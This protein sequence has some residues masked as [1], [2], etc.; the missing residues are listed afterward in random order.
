MLSENGTVVTMAGDIGDELFGGYH[1][2]FFMMNS[3]SKPKNWRDFIWMWMHKFAKPIKLNI[4]VNLRDLHSILC[5]ILPENL[6]NSED[7]GNSAMALDCVT[8]VPEDFFSR[9]D[10]Y[11][12]AFSMEGRFPFASKK[13]IQ[14]C[15][16][17]KS[18]LFLNLAATSSR[19]ILKSSISLSYSSMRFSIGS[20][21]SGTSQC[22]NQL[23]CAT[24]S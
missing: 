4:D 8:T 22:L 6:W 7:I 3:E 2:Y 23:P 18:N 1:K 10:K 20:I 11:G 24:S 15:L 21:A 5:E 16:S 14:Y 17:I 9:N 12:M 19:A 13:Y